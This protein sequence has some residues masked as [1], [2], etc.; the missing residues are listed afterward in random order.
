M[1]EQISVSDNDRL[2]WAVFSSSLAAAGIITG[3]RVNYLG[4]ASFLIQMENSRANLSAISTANASFLI[5][6]DIHS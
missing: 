2:N 6:F 1:N 4:L 5:N 3:F